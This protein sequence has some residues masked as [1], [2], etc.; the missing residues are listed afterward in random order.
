MRGGCGGMAA[1]VVVT[2]LYYCYEQLTHPNPYNV[3]T[4]FELA[5]VLA[6]LGAIIGLLAWAWYTSD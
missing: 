1:G 5:P 6:I 2:L 4:L 3:L